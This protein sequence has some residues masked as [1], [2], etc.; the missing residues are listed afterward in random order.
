MKIS[1]IGGGMQIPGE[2][3]IF[4]YLNILAFDNLRI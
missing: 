1:F 3:L 2:A 4:S